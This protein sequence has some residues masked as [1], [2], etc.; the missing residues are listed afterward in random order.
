MTDDI[1]NN[2]HAEVDRLNK[3]NIK[4]NADNIIKH[5]IKRASGVKMTPKEINIVMKEYKRRHAQ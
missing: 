1:Y 3:L 4:K 5:A 2:I